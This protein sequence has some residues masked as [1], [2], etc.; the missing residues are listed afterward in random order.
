MISRHTHQTSVRYLLPSTKRDIEQWQL[1]AA[2]DQFYELASQ[3]AN[4]SVIEDQ[5]CPTL[6]TLIANTKTPEQMFE[7]SPTLIY[8]SG[9]KDVSND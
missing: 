7:Q 4:R 6:D 5:T 1:D 3:E 9:W 2:T 8:D